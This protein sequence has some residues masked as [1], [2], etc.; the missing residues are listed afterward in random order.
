M[1]VYNV[2]LW[3]IGVALRESVKKRVALHANGAMKM[4][5]FSDSQAAIRWT[6]HLVLGSGQPLARWISCNARTFRKVGIETETHWVPGHTGIPGNEEADR[7]AN[8][9]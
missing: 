3:V 4:A 5:I 9:A 6:E 7:Q 8:L 2:E 1:E